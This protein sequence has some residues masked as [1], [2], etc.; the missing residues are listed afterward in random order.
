M[1]YGVPKRAGETQVAAAGLVDR[2]RV[3]AAGVDRQLVR[4]PSTGEWVLSL[5]G[6]LEDMGKLPCRHFIAFKVL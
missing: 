1:G 3:Q 2:E 4:G 5:W 6:S